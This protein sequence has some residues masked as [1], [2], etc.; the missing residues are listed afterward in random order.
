MTHFTSLIPAFTRSPSQRQ[1]AADVTPG[2]RPAY[3]IKETDEAWG[4]T[5]YLPGVSKSGLSITDAEGVLTIRGE[6]GWKQPGGWT[7]LYRESSDLPFVLNLEHDNGFDSEKVHAELRDGV[8]RVSL[9]KAEERKPR[10][11]AVT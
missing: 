7:S 5:V 1:T 3:E 9:P 10:K 2:I 6:R 11:I 8:L 4:L